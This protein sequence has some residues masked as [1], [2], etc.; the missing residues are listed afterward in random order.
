MFSPFET[1]RKTQTPRL[2][3]AADFVD[4]LAGHKVL[5]ALSKPAILCELNKPLQVFKAIPCVWHT[6]ILVFLEVESVSEAI[7]LGDVAREAGV[8]PSTVSRILN[9]TAVVAPSKRAAVE[10]V[11][12][13]LGYQ[14][15]VLARGLALGQSMSIGV[16][17]QEISSPYYAEV[18]IGIEKGLAGTDYHP[19]VVS[20][21]WRAEAERE[22]LEVLLARRVDA[23]VIMDGRL[24]EKHLLR[25]AQGTPVMVVGRV[26]AGL[27][28]QCLRVDNVHGAFL[29]TQHLIDLG[30]KRIAHI[31]GP[32]DNLDAQDRLAGFKLAL[33]QAKIKFDAS[34]VVEGDFNERSG[35]LGVDALLSR[36]TNFSALVCGNDQMAIGAR[37]ALY[38]RGIRVPDDISLVGFDD[39]PGS[40]FTTPPMTTVRQPSQEAGLAA[41]AAVLDLL[42]GRVPKLSSPPPLL[43]IRESTAL[44]RS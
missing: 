30:H 27:E 23:I 8:S 22:A 26:I 34:L 16:L 10:A 2:N 41:A 6:G 18:L 25:A 29:G 14:P 3:E 7:T 21:H 38:R 12:E 9:G 43:V 32:K 44:Y 28:A 17:M 37:L 39:I 42:A 35:L 19:I 40:S 13:K 24:E 11:I 4:R 33:E 15:N 5:T 31:S 36:S 20:G 1:V